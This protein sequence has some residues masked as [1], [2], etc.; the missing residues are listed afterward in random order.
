[1]SGRRPNQ[2]RPGQCSAASLKR[3]NVV[4]PRVHDMRRPLQLCVAL[5]QAGNAPFLTSS[6]NARARRMPNA[7]PPWPL[8]AGPT[9]L[10]SKRGVSDV[11]HT[12]VPR[13]RASSRVNRLQAVD[14]GPLSQRRA[15]RVEPA[16]PTQTDVPRP[17]PTI[18][19]LH[20]VRL[21]GIAH[22]PRTYACGPLKAPFMCSPAP[23]QAAL[24]HA[25][26]TA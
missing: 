7:Y 22:P 24:K 19:T 18:C 5:A 16:L 12:T 15:E 25:G 8:V 23:S 26:H 21:I 17:H 1:M 10:R 14:G 9:L 3:A 11:L 13:A 4:A 6:W 20:A 2:P